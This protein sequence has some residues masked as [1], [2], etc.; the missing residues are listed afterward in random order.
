MTP[1]E[2]VKILKRNVVDLVSEEELLDRIRRK[3]KL[4]VKLGV[5]PSRPDLHLGHAVVL[6]KLREFQ[7]LGH[8]VVLIIGDFTARIGDPSGRN[9]TRPM[10]TKEEVLENAKTYQEQA[11]K[12]LDPERTELR[13]NG[14]WLDRMTFADVIV[15]ASKYTVARMLERDDFARRFRE[16]IPITISE[17]LYP[18]AQAYDS[19]AIQA[20]V[21]LGGTDQL[22]NLLVGRKIQ[23]E[24]GQEPQIVM[25]MPIIEGTDGKLKMS[26]SYGNYIAFN[27]TPEDMYGKLMSI[28]DELII[29]YMR[30]LT[31]IPEEQ[32]EEYERKMKEGKINPRDVKMV[33]AYE[34]TRFFHGEENAKKAQEHFVKVFQRKEL[35]DEMPV[36]ELSQEMNIVDLLV[37]IGAVSS[38]SEAKRLI[39]Q[40]GVYLDGERVEDIKFIVKPDGERVLRVGKKKFYRIS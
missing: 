12:I 37:K 15:L 5:D 16:G 33:L 35:P 22:F 34:I 1:E 38:R 8:T 20:D 7:D 14:E 28:P 27:D 40:G 18:L 10:L 11:F 13:F 36:V 21:E 6:R 4:R 19:V 24:Y 17:F 26:K 39:S 23:E 32:I 3:G 25:T 2:Q 30:L 31:D 29:K 9:E